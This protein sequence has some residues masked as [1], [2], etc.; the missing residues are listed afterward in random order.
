M[1]PPRFGHIDSPE[2]IL[3]HSGLSVHGRRNQKFAVKTECRAP[4]L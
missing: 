4:A 3:K 1:N 2:F